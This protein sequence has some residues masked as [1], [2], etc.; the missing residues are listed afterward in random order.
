MKLPVKRIWAGLIAFISPFL[1]RALSV[2]A[3]KIVKE[4][5]PMFGTPAIDI[6]KDLSPLYV[7]PQLAKMAERAAAQQKL[8]PLDSPKLGNLEEELNWIIRSFEDSIGVIK[9]ATFLQVLKTFGPEQL[10]EVM[11]EARNQRF[12]LLLL[13][14]SVL[15][16]PL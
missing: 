13:A 7:S 10:R 14:N 15:P 8:P 5:D 16:P 6:P 1:A 9:N 12:Q 11:D 4:L 2:V 3:T